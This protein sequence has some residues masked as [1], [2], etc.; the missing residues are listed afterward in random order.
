MAFAD[1]GCTEGLYVKY[2][3]LIHNGTFCVDADIARTTGYI[4]REVSFGE[5][6]FRAFDVDSN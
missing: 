5:R 3:A 2:L 4:D 6:M 1:I